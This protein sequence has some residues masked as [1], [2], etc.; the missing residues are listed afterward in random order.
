MKFSQNQKLIF[1]LVLFAVAG[2]IVY[3]SFFSANTTNTAGTATSGMATTT[4]D[5]GSQDIINMAS[6]I[7]TISIDSN[8]FSSPLFLSLIDFDAPLTPEPQGRPNPF[9][10]I[11]NDTGSATV[12]ATSSPKSTK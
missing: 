11:G 2:F 12:T 4:I 9:A 7:D 3:Q 8:L 6:Q 1:A 10:N 5:S